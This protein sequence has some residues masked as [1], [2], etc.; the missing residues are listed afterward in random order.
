M[1]YASP[2]NFALPLMFFIATMSSVWAAESPRQ[3]PLELPKEFMPAE[4]SPAKKPMSKSIKLAKADMAQDPVPAA[5]SAVAKPAAP[6]GKPLPEDMVAPVWK[7]H[8]VVAG[9]TLDKLVKKYYGNS[10]L[11]VEVLRDWVVVNNPKAFTKVNTKKL[12]PGTVLN[13]ADQAEL[14]Q[15][16]MPSAVSKANVEPNSPPANPLPAPVGG[17]AAHQGGN[18]QALVEPN[19]RNWVRYP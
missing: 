14:I 1:L 6:V 5:S 3:A 9:D 19:K 7:T 13:L 2:R 4:V 16:L 15:K 18:F 11:K 12:Q 8:T 17:A 10:P